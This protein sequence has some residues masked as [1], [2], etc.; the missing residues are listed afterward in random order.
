[1]I[2]FITDEFAF[3]V[4]LLYNGHLGTEESGRCKK[5][6]VVERWPLAGVRLYF[7]LMNITKF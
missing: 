6:V 7:L 4:E 3:S 1:M 2:S 5:E